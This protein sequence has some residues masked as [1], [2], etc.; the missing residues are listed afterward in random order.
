MKVTDLFEGKELSYTDKKLIL[1]DTKEWLEKAG[2]TP[3]QVKTAIAEIKRTPEFERIAKAL[4]YIG[5]PKMEQN[6]S[7]TFEGGDDWIAH[8]TAMG[9]IRYSTVSQWRSMRRSSFDTP[10]RLASPKP[11]LV[12]GNGHASL[13]KTLKRALIELA[14]K[15]KIRTLIQAAEKG[16]VDEAIEP[17]AAGWYLTHMKSDRSTEIMQGPMTEDAVDTAVEN[18]GGSAK[19]WGK[20][21]VSK[22]AIDKAKAAKAIGMVK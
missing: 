12:H 17:R 14:K 19:G 10:T 5:T 7:L 15:P 9:Q 22:M 4:K 8:I 6:G 20:T 11:A 3:A 13:V 18:K 1:G 16:Q 21:F 2:V